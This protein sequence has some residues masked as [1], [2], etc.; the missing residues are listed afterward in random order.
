MTA[1]NAGRSAGRA[2]AATVS[3]DNVLA[4]RLRRQHLHR[5][6]PAEALVATVADVC[7][8]HAQVITSAELTAWARVDDLAPGAVRR[9]LWDER[10]LVKTWAMRGT[11]HL[12]PAA[13]LPLWVAALKVLGPRHHAPSWLRYFGLTRAD[14][15]AVLDAIPRALDGCS[16]TRQELADA[17]AASTGLPHLGEKLRESWGALL[18][19]AALNGDLCFAPGEGPTV[20]FVR[21]DQ[22]LPTWS[23]VEPDDAIR[24]V[25]RRYLAAYGPATREEFARW[26]GAASPAK[27]GALV[28][29]LGD[30][31]ARVEIEG[32]RAWLLTD[33]VAELM[34]A[35]PSG[36][37]RL[38]PAFDHYVVA[39]LRDAPAVLPAAVKD[40]VYRPQGW[41]SP[42]LLVDG[43]IAGVWRHVERSGR[44]AVRIEPFDRVP[45]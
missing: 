25:V 36:T 2:P 28:E 17:V 34:D 6:M 1:K 32:K 40:R 14:A 12:L 24:E 37:V 44:L 30:E 10:A 15:D 11:L 29:R 31:V 22:W 26:L 20:R 45:D 16:L 33:H 5:R 38:L 19:P 4:W 7:G 13:E 18:K 42:V 43:R 23:D 9:A 39:A 3:W 41:L 35:S 27:A 21:P 8:L